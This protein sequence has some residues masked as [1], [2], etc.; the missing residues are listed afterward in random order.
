[1]FCLTFPVGIKQIDYLNMDLQGI[2]MKVLKNF[3]FHKIPVKVKLN[4]DS[5]FSCNSQF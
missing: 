2:E 3:P 4:L 5:Y 1:M